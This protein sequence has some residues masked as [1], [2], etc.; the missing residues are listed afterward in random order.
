[1]NVHISELKA[2]VEIVER[3]NEVLR[4]CVKRVIEAGKDLYKLIDPFLDKH[5]KCIQWRAITDECQKKVEKKN[6]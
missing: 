2:H 1:M 5:D 6:E 4:Y 3:E